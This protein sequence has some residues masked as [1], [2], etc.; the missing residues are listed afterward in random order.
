MVFIKNLKN[1]QKKLKKL[2]S[3]L[4]SVVNIQQIIMFNFDKYQEIKKNIHFLGKK[5]R[6]IAISKNHPLEDV[7]NAI[8][9]GLDIFGENRVQEA[10][11]KFETIKKRNNEVKLHLTG[12]LQSNKVKQ[13]LNLFDVIHTLD[14]IKLLKEFAKFSEIIQEKSF[15]VQINTG[16]EVSK[17]GVFPED[18][19]NFLDL[20]KTYG[21][22]N[23]KGLMCIPPVNENPNKH[24]QIINDLTK[25]LGL[26]RPSIGMSSDY[27][28]A[29]NFDPKYI[30]LGTVLFGKRQ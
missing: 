22:K 6:I 20:C 10:R 27:M 24:F 12:P 23:I 25:E 29:L 15:F 7:E 3:L 28:D 2:I 18:A 19:K 9:C 17:S 1:V 14:R 16:K 13:A 30:R 4:K 21:I 11:L 26:G 5:T 8:S